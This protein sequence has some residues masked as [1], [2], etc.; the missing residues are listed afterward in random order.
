MR[1]MPFEPPTD[2]Y[3]EKVLSIDEQIC[4]LIKQRKEISNN[5]PGFP[6]DSQISSWAKKYE[7]YEQLLRNL[8][9]TLHDDEVFR[10]YVEPEGFRKNLQVLK[11]AEMNNCLFT[12]PFI[13]QYE[14]ASVVHFNIDWDETI[15]SSDERFNHRFYGLF[16]GENYD[17]RASGGGGTAG[18]M[19]I[20]FIVSPPL[21]DNIAGLTFT[22][23][24][25]SIPYRRKPTGI[26]IVMNFE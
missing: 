22:F 14:N 20:N 17:C 8:F 13:R 15:S 11:I 24:E 26:E 23:T 25:Y 16:I 10:P 5:N 3:D 6:S 9:I 2:H 1:R 7:L 21:P 12:V 4:S 18:H 19:S